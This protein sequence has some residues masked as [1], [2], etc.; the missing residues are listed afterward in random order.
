MQKEISIHNM[1]ISAFASGT[2]VEH[3]PLNLRESDS[4]CTNNVLIF[5]AH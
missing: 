5:R 3:N 2:N 1:L 4:S